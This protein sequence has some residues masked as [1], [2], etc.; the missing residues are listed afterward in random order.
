M[1]SPYPNSTSGASSETPRQVE[2]RT[3]LAGIERNTSFSQ[4][5]SG[6]LNQTETEKSGSWDKQP[7]LSARERGL[8]EQERK[9]SDSL[10]HEQR[11]TRA[12][13][14]RPGSTVPG[15]ENVSAELQESGLLDGTVISWG[16]FASLI[17]LGQPMGMAGTTMAGL[18]PPVEMSTNM[19]AHLA[20]D[21]ANAY[22]EKNGVQ[23]LTMNLEPDHLGRVEVRLQARGDQLSVR[24]VAASPEAESAMRENLKDLTE[25]IQTRTGRYQQV[26]VRVELKESQEQDPDPSDEDPRDSQGQD[27]KQDQEPGTDSDNETDRNP[28]HRVETKS[29]SPGQG[30]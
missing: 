18:S 6:E 1:I 22:T 17:Q 24:L 12:A 27:S 19:V 23:T 15:T 8:A 7:G 2:T 4:L 5:L 20:A 30:G 14:Q 16:G 11:N 13:D 25:A 21:I 28:D 26:E 29:G 10:T 9:G 3:N